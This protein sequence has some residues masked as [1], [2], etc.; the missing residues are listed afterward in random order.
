[1]DR[2]PIVVSPESV[3][4]LVAVKQHLAGETPSRVTGKTIVDVVRD[5]GFVQ[6]DPISVVA[7]SHLLSLRSRLGNFDPAIL[8][9]LL[10]NERK[11]FEHW[12]PI[13]SLVLT[14]DYPLYYSLMR[15]YPE[16]MSRSW[17]IQGVRAA[18]YLRAHGPLRK[19]ILAELRKGPRTLG[20]FSDHVRTKRDDG[21]WAP[22][23]DVSHMLWH[24]TMSGDVMVVGHAGAQNLWGLTKDF[25]PR[26]AKRELLP[27]SKFEELSAERSL[28]AQG[29]ATPREILFYFVRGRYV[30]LDRTLERLEDHSK[31]LRIQIAG[32]DDRKLRYIHAQD[33]PLLESLAEGKG[34]QPR[35]SLLPPFDNL[36]GNQDR[37][38]RL[39]EFDYVREQFFPAERRRFGFYVLPVLRGDRFIG[40]IDPRV[41]RESKTLVVNSVHAEKGAPSDR[42][43]GRELGEAIDD[44]ATFVGVNRVKYTSK[45]PSQWQSALN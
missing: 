5:L 31:I 23:S 25:L 44:L 34:W 14:E 37:L 30:T 26:W 28:L 24:L 42:S 17:G 36:V 19:R 3:R 11:V 32:L 40:R 18:K 27:E 16:S 15:R 13:A 8:E 4:R 43:T 29:V 6:W 1:M 41:D 9:R 12:T 10:W 35:L 38:R 45:V 20:E 22:T 33:L 39:F 7:P 2:S 21:E